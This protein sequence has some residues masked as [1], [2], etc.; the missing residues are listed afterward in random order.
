[1]KANQSIRLILTKLEELAGEFP[2][3][4]PRA[5]EMNKLAALFPLKFKGMVMSDGS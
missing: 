1:V 3:D 4:G 2:S 5:V